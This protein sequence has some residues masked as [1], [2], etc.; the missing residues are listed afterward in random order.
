ML[1]HAWGL[2]CRAGARTTHEHP[3]WLTILFNSFT[4]NAPSWAALKASAS[5]AGACLIVLILGGTEPCYHQLELL[6]AQCK[7]QAQV[8]GP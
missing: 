6:Q 3:T 8:P 2:E 5:D 7:V 1:A 4:R